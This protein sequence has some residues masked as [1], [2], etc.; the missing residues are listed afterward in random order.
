M[1]STMI[2]TNETASLPRKEIG[3]YQGI[4]I[5]SIKKNSACNQLGKKRSRFS[6]SKVKDERRV[7]F[8]DSASADAVIGRSDSINHRYQ[9]DVLGENTFHDS[10]WYTRREMAVF[11]SQARDYVLGCGNR[12]TDEDSR[13]Y[14]RYD[15][16]R[17]QRK[18]MTRKIIVLLMQEKSLND[19]E[20]AM[21]ANRS[22]SWAVEEAFVLGCM[23]FCEAYHPEMSHI[24]RCQNDNS[25]GHSN[26]ESIILSNATVDNCEI[27]N[28]R[29]KLNP[30]SDTAYSHLPSHVA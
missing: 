29:R 2:R 3:N 18:A 28:K 11:T 13:G 17:S 12:C 14:E 4:K 23:D 16:G 26:P 19:E 25:V 8:S 22:A 5:Q 6:I 7:H 1:M 9:M 24:L 30:K 10:I 27:Q 15:F 20:K 21:I